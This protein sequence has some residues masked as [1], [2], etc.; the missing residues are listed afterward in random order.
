[1]SQTLAL[2]ALKALM[3][4]FPELSKKDVLSIAGVGCSSNQKIK[5]LEEMMFKCMQ[6]YTQQHG[7][8]SKAK[9]VKTIKN[10]W[11]KQF[12]EGV[13]KPV[14]LKSAYQ[15][16][17]KEVMPEVIKMYPGQTRKD[18]MMFI[19]QMWKDRKE[20]SAVASESNMDIQDTQDT[21]TDEVE[22]LKAEKVKRPRTRT[23]T[24]KV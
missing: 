19:G 17:L 18:R 20:E 12:P 3:A 7:E 8:V 9:I 11:D 4:E 15:E 10:V 22:M 14:R 23:S 21:S 16:F 24:S 5:A 13:V 1:M 6:E 2:E